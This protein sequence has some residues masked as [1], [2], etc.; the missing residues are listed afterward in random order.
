MVI[1]ELKPTS[2]AAAPKVVK[3]SKKGNEISDFFVTASKQDIINKFGQKD[4]D[5]GSPEVQVALASHKITHLALH[6]ELN[7]KDNHS[8][9]GLLKIISKRRRI[10]NYLA[11][12]DEAR[13]QT[14]HPE[15][16]N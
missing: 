16:P 2:A 4:G 8:R 3:K 15:P 13:Y 5:T 10:L 7:P 12:Q 6:L 14:T 11:S 1:P 9:R